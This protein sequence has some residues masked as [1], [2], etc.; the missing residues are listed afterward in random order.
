[1][2]RECLDHLLIVREQHLSRVL[3]AYVAYFNQARPHQGLH[4]QIP[5]PPAVR[6]AEARD[7][8]I[9][10]VPILGGLHHHYCRAA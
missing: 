2:R 10:D 6:P 7:G 3:Q 1:M 8:P 4:Q 9:L 5:H